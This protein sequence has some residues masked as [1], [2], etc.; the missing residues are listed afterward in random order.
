MVQECAVLLPLTVVLDI[1]PYFYR[2][3]AFCSEI[4]TSQPRFS[5]GD[6]RAC[7]PA[8]SAGM[9]CSVP[10]FGSSNL[11]AIASKL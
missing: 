5:I 10:E 8:S 3:G 2:L 6:M 1:V 7:L 4:Y 11:E 9:T